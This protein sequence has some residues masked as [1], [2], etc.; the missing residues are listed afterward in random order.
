MFHLPKR[1]QGVNCLNYL[2]RRDITI[3][4]GKENN[5]KQRKNVTGVILQANMRSSS[6]AKKAK[7]ITVRSGE[8]GPPY[9]GLYGKGLQPKGLPFSGFRYIKG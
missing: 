5:R 2:P 1:T 3:C 7:G 8:G 9:N 4:I 6:S